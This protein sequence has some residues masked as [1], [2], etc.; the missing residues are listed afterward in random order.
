MKLRYRA[1]NHMND[2]TFALTGFSR[3]KRFLTLVA[4]RLKAEAAAFVYSVT[5]DSGSVRLASDT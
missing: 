1:G 2:N 4:P 5:V 3:R